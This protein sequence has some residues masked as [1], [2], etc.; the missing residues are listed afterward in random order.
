MCAIGHF[1][2][3]FPAV[4]TRYRH[5]AHRPA[6]THDAE[7]WKR[8]LAY[9]LLPRHTHKISS[10]Y[11]YCTSILGRLPVTST[12]CYALITKDAVQLTQNDVTRS[13]PTLFT[14]VALSAGMVML[15]RRGHTAGK[16]AGPARIR[17]LGRCSLEMSKTQKQKKKAVRG[18]SQ[19][20]R[21][22]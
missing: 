5:A 18:L 11:D 7:D 9:S 3:T 19:V 22:L 1:R 14:C 4:H 8:K 16:T 6:C 10:T 2:L 13:T 12:N 21:H 20:V 17:P 15:M